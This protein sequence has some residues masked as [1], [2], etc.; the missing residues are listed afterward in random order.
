V[1]RGYAWLRVA[2]PFVQVTHH[3]GALVAC[4]IYSFLLP[5]LSSLLA[6][7]QDWLRHVQPRVDFYFSQGPSGLTRP[8]AER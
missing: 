4:F 3:R 7:S 1:T 8:P 6:A 2:H 5:G